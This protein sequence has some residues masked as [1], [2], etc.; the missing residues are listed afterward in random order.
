MDNYL[1]TVPRLIVRSFMHCKKG[2]VII[3]LCEVEVTVS[4]YSRDLRLC[5]FV[6]VMAKRESFF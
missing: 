2:D 5:I 3:I 1:H 4:G 6:F